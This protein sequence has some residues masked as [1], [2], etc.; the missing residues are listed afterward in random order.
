MC[1][2]TLT[3][4]E[5]HFALK[6]YFH[7][8]PGRC[9]GRYIQQHW[10]ALNLVKSTFDRTWIK[11][12]I[13]LPNKLS[14][15]YINKII[16]SRKKESNHL[17]IYTAKP[18]YVLMLSSYTPKWRTDFYWEVNWCIILRNGLTFAIWDPKYNLGITDYFQFGIWG[19]GALVHIKGTLVLLSNKEAFRTFR[20]LILR[21]LCLRLFFFI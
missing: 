19:A 8:V 6:L 5:A 14:W 11:S 3:L 15:L 10:G 16:I 18:T 4:R 17:Y 9:L 12:T 7:L 1:M 20:L 21:K 13:W 2:C